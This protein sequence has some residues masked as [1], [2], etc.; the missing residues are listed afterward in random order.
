M[1]RISLCVR[2]SLRTARRI[3]R[4]IVRIDKPTVRPGSPR[5][6]GGSA[7]EE[8]EAA[9]QASGAR[10]GGAPQAYVR[11][12]GDRAARAGRRPTRGEGGQSSRDYTAAGQ[13]YFGIVNGVHD[14]FGRERCG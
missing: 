1:Y 8:A 5:A 9:A 14:G 12:V 4:A 13:G 6:C 11:P 2:F 10:G 3:V 7:E